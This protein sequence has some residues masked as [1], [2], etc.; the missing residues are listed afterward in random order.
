MT[1]AKFATRKRLIV[2]GASAAVVAAG[3][4]GIV[5]VQAQAPDAGTRTPVVADV[6]APNLTQSTHLSLA[7][8]TK[9]AQTALDAAA[10]EN[11]KVS[12]A[13]VDRN[14]NVIV[15]LRGDGAGPQSYTAAQQK[16]FTAVSWNAP[17]TELSK[18]LE[19][20]PR[21]ADIDGTLFLGGGTPV[22][23]NGAPVAGIGVAGA[24]SGDQDEKFAKAGA[25][26][27]S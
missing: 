17:T 22:K 24:P 12:V 13:V 18:R 1:T 3:A 14:G 7:A 23:A 25:A 6:S 19:S 9:A 20:A 26:A 21:L 5:S 15:T 4:V 10:K 2:A 27:L 8:A 11:V 16:A